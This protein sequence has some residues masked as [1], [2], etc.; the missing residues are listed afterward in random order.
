MFMKIYKYYTP[1]QSWFECDIDWNE[2][3]FIWSD[4]EQLLR[5]NNREKQAFFTRSPDHL[6][7]NNFRSK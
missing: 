3:G 1:S 4:V 7:Q 2:K 5:Q 6:Q